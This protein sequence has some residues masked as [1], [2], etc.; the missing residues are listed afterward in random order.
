[1]G[2][3]TLHADLNQ[4]YDFLWAEL[5]SLVLGNSL[6]AFLASFLILFVIDYLLTRHLR[7]TIRYLKEAR[8]RSSL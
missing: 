7:E 1:M 3:L 5:F 8:D 6:K 2:T 4:I